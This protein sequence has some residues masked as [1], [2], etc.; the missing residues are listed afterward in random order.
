MQGSSSEVTESERD[1]SDLGLSEKRLILIAA[2][3]QGLVLYALKSSAAVEA[4]SPVWQFL[5]Y[6]IT[7]AIPPLV[8][9]SIA[10]RLAHS[11]WWIIGGYALLL[12]LLGLYQGYQCTPADQ[13]RCDWPVEFSITMVIATFILAFMLRASATGVQHLKTPEYSGLFHYSWDNAL[14]AALT[15]VFAGIF[16]LILQL[17]QA[18]FKLVGVDFFHYLFREEWFIFP[19][20]WLVAGCGA[21]L[22]RSQQSFVLTLKRLLRTMLVALLPL[23][24]VLT[25]VFLATLPFTGLQPIWDTGHGSA[26]LLWLVALLLFFTNGVIQDEF[27]FSRYPKWINRVLLLALAIAPFYAAFGLYGVY[28]RVDQYGWTPERLWG[29]VVALTLALLALSYSISILRRGAHWADWLRRINTGLALWVLAVCVVTQLPLLNFARISADSQVERLRDGRVALADFDFFFLRQKLGRAGLDAL[30][31]LREMP[32][33]Q[34]N[35]EVADHLDALLTPGRPDWALRENPL[36]ATARAQRLREIPIFPEGAELP[37]HSAALQVEGKDCERQ[38]RACLWLAQDLDGDGTLEYL[39]FVHSAS[40]N[41]DRHWLQVIAYAAGDSGWQV[42]GNNSRETEEPFDALK[43][44][45]A[46]GQISLRPSRW[47]GLYLND[48]LLFDPTQ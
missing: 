16:W 31:E 46:T 44:R 8:I 32:Q 7:L 41:K 13:I 34:Q 33:V 42:V 45:L 38:E 36:Q 26:L 3:L 15:L 22:F 11:Y 29:F 2:L 21:I 17:W 28:L 25:I 47:Q 40:G 19:V 43:Q 30:E 1:D 24:A 5:C 27:P 39:L 6:T 37:P 10:P 18:L 14:T 23:L 48:E 20:T 4:W 35:T 12:A 9:I